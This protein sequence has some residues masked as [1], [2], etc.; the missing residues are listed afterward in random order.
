MKFIH[1]NMQPIFFLQPRPNFLGWTGQKV[2]AGLVSSAGEGQM[3]G[4]RV[5]SRLPSVTGR[6]R[7]AV[8]FSYYTASSPHQVQ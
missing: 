2:L 6:V 3:G 4:G 7:E 8:N 5:Q 1:Y